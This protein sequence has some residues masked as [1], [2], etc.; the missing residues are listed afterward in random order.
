MAEHHFGIGPRLRAVI[1]VPHESHG[2]EIKAFVILNE[3][4]KVTFTA[5]A[6]GSYEFHCE[7]HPATMKGTITVGG[8]PSS[9]PPAVTSGGRGD[10][11]SDDSTETTQTDEGY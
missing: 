9:N 10:S 2:E 5:P 4:A 7:Y 1:G 8:T 3:D 6:A 11:G